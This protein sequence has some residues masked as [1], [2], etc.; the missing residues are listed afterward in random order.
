MK[1]FTIETIRAGQPS[2]VRSVPKTKREVSEVREKREIKP[3]LKVEVLT[4]IPVPEGYIRCMVIQ[5]FEGM[6]ERL[7]A[8]DIIDVP[9]RRFRSLVF[10]GL[11]EQYKGTASPNKRR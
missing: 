2:E 1:D 11:V 6:T 3:Q 10:R 5:N 8:G 9:E 4:K 7:E